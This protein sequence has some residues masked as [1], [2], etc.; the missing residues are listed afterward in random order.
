MTN[1]EFFSEIITMEGASEEIKAFALESIAKLDKR[2]A[3]RKARPSKTAK[4]NMPIKAEILALLK[5][6]KTVLI[7]SEIAD[8]LEISTSKASALCKQL[9]DNGEI[10][11]EEVKVKGG[12]KVKGYS[13][14]D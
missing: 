2:N 14:L 8:S 3:D 10:K 12:R 11:S 9:V 7:A 1:R 5:E 4:E 13:A 6:A